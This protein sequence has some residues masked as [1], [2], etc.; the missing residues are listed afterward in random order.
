MRRTKGKKLSRR[1]FIK[2][3]IGTAVGVSLAVKSGYGMDFESKEKSKVLEVF[4]PNVI[5]KNRKI[6]QAIVRRMIQQGMSGLTNS[7]NPWMQFIHP[8]DRVGLK[9]NTLGRPLLYTHDELIQAIVEELKD[10]G[11]KEN[12]II[13]WDRYERHML[14]SKFTLNTSEK[15]I[16]VYG[17]DT[18]IGGK[19]RL[20]SDVVY[21]SDLDNSEKR[22]PENST[23]ST[24]SS[25][26][27]QECDK[28]IN[29]AI[30]K[31]HGLAGVTLCLK[32]L[33]YGISEN[34]ARFHGPEHIG[35]FISEFCTHPLLKKKVVLHIIDGLE[36]CFDGGPVPDNTNN[37]FTPKKLWL[38]TDPVALDTVGRRVIETERKKRGLPSLQETGRPI[39]HIELS[40]AQGVGTCKPDK[41]D[42][43]KIQL[44]E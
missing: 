17:T 23:D 30:L 26:F 10:I 44:E 19:K 12:N 20:D 42:L 11:V 25:I 8:G 34:N 39:D 21:R 3:S 5:S 38:G 28:I 9:I 22:N 16:R 15:G 24:F 13:V 18:R 6:D 33:A 1:K 4:H 37:L 36:G 27:T 35:P 40:A 43:K 32:N 41:I 29:L 2:K 14:K 31:D 7:K